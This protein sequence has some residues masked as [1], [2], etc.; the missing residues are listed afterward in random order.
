MSLN[1]SELI[2]QYIGNAPNSWESTPNNQLAIKKLI[3][4]RVQYTLVG[5]IY[6]F[7]RVGSKF[8]SNI[9]NSE[10]KKELA[11]I[12]INKDKTKFNLQYYPLNSNDL[13]IKSDIPIKDLHIAINDLF[14]AGF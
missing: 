7:W 13:Q 9:H 14:G 2:A 8:R 12:V 6:E 10:V 4:Y 11:M 1:N 3:P 5:D